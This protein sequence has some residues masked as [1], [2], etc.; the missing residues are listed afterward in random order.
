M[1]FKNCPGAASFTAY[2]LEL[3]TYLHKQFDTQLLLCYKGTQELIEQ[4]IFGR[5]LS[6][7]LPV[8]ILPFL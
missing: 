3:L 2:F 7:W 4:S 8:W 6:A 5:F 1:C